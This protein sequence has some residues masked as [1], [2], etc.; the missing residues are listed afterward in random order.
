M[1]GLSL[2]AMNRLLIAVA[3]L[4]EKRELQSSGFS[5]CGTRARCATACGVFRDWGSN[6]CLLHW[7][8]ES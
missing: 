2:V 7:Q 3:S 8:A 5:S 6:P 4:I 1:S